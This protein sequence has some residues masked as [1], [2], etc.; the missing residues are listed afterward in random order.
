VRF[1]H[2]L[3]PHRPP[4]LM[5][6]RVYVFCHA[7]KWL[8]QPDHFRP[9]P[10]VRRPALLGYIPHRIGH[11]PS[12]WPICRRLVALDG[13]HQGAEVSCGSVG[14]NSRDH[15]AK[16]QLIN[17]QSA[18]KGNNTSRMRHPNEYASEAGVMAGGGSWNSSGAIHLCNLVRSSSLCRSSEKDIRIGA[19]E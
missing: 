7:V 2:V 5:P 9:F 10:W 17:A 11:S 6:M 4:R 12:G 13:L 1:N 15:L 8:K 18:N 3:S 16:F 19:S 14:S